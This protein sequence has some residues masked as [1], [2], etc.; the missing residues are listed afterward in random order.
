MNL[1]GVLLLVPKS[2]WLFEDT[3]HWFYCI[4]SGVGVMSVFEIKTGGTHP[5]LCFT[6][7]LRSRFFLLLRRI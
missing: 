1:M 5:Y 7:F 2:A 3:P 4:V 6:A